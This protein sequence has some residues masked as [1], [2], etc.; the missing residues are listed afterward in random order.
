M[1]SQIF[2]QEKEARGER[3][4]NSLHFLVPLF[5]KLWSHMFSRR[6]NSRMREYDMEVKINLIIYIKKK[7]ESCFNST[8]VEEI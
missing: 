1:F 6:H 7:R 2:L 8:Y 3:E 4:I 5:V